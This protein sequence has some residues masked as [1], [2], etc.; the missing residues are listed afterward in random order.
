MIVEYQ[1]APQ[2]RLTNGQAPERPTTQAAENGVTYQ[3][4]N[5][6]PFTPRREAYAGGD[7][8]PVTPAPAPTPAPAQPAQPAQPSQPAEPPPTFRQMRESGVARPAPPTSTYQAN[9]TYQPISAAPDTGGLREQ[10]MAM[11][12]NPNS[13]YGSE[14][15]MSAYRSGARDIDDDFA[16][17]QTRAREEMVARGLSDSSI[18]GGRYADLNVGQRE[19]KTSLMDS[20]LREKA[21]SDEASKQASLGM[22]LQLAG[23]DSN[24]ALQT[25]QINATREGNYLDNQWR[26]A[27]LDMRGRQFDQNFGLEREKFDT[28]NEQ[29]QSE[30]DQRAD[31]FTRNLDA[32]QMSQMLQ[33]LQMMGFDGFGSGSVPIT[34]AY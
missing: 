14:Q 18:A 5:G 32:N 6:A 21:K 1:R 3:G 2:Y 13:A 7:D 34:T 30:F 10:L 33:F 19:A 27:D 24:A 23:I 22:L 29:W 26:Y 25:A 15:V 4:G 20:L 12:G 17:R 11:L 28:G 9:Y 31:Q 8:A 16:M